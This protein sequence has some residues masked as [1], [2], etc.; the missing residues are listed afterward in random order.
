MK[1]SL[2]T[3]NSQGRFSISPGAHRRRGPLL[4]QVHVD[5]D[6]QLRALL[7]LL[8]LPLLLLLLLLRVQVLRRLQMRPL[9]LDKLRSL[10]AMVNLGLKNG[11]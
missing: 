4:R 6:V 7:L 8:L 10:R 3:F 2:L 9:R 11:I 1:P 5:V